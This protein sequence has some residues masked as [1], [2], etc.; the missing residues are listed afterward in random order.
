MQLKTFSIS[1]GPPAKLIPAP[2][3]VAFTVSQVVTPA[4]NDNEIIRTS[5]IHSYTSRFLAVHWIESH[6]KKNN[7]YRISYYVGGQMLQEGY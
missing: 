5:F 6:G 1:P 7:L 3:A 2:V 4:I